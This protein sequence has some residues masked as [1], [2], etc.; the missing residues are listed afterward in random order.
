MKD[1]NKAIKRRRLVWDELQKNGIVSLNTIN[2]RIES[3]DSGLQKIQR[4]TLYDDIQFLREFFGQQIEKSADRGNDPTFILLNNYVATTRHMRSEL[5]A[6]KKRIINKI[7]GSLIL[8]NL[9]LNE[10]FQKG[11]SQFDVPV[12]QNKA[13]LSEDSIEN[14]LMTGEEL[15]A[16][17]NRPVDLC[18]QK[19][20][21]AHASMQG[22]AENLRGR[23]LDMLEFWCRSVRRTLCID[24]GSSNELFTKNILRK[25]QLPLPSLFQMSVWTN[26]IG[27]FN[28]LVNPPID[29]LEAITVAGT[30]QRKTGSL[31]G[32]LAL[33][34]LEAINPGFG[35]GVVGC[36]ALVF[37]ND[38][39]SFGADSDTDAAMKAE[40]L[41]RSTLRIVVADSSKWSNRP[42]SGYYQFGR[43]DPQ[44]IHLVITD[45]VRSEHMLKLLNQ[46]TYVLAETVDE[47]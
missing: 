1:E 4:P 13:N 44:G 39:V 26:N 40:F 23:I 37:E 16:I 21:A 33:K 42:Y 12:I 5:N 34:S 17:I 28:A 38:K 19:A 22:I 30:P 24:A 47:N 27:V 36:T 32:W 46:G 18:S 3:S 20:S 35:V 29:G 41:T 45:R 15:E 6:D 9:R 11:S 10:V 14:L 7:L 8:A 43:P 25:L 2:L 31:G